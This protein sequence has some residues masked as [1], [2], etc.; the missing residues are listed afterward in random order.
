MFEKYIKNKTKN[1]FQLLL[2]ETIDIIENICKQSESPLYLNILHQLYDMKENVIEVEL[3]TGWD[4]INER[5]SIGGLAVKNFSEGTD[6]RN[7]LCA[8]FGG[9]MD[10]LDYPDL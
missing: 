7:R 10:Y 8:L 6:I 3:F 1:N 4:D 9:A 5:Y 2:N